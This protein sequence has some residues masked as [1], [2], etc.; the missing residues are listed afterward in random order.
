MH[1]FL[2][3]N[4]AYWKVSPARCRRFLVKSHSSAISDSQSN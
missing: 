4:K 3:A 1:S 2:A